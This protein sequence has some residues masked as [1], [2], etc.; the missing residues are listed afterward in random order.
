MIEK[1]EVGTF[2]LGGKME[3]TPSIHSEQLINR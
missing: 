2:F 3:S 1:L